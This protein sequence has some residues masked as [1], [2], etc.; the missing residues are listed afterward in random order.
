MPKRTPC[1]AL[2]RGVNVGAHGQVAMADLAEVLVTIGLSDV[3]TY[4]RSGNAVF[5]AAP[6]VRRGLAFRIEE[7]FEARFGFR[8]AV[9]V[10]G[11]DEFAR[12]ARDDPFARL[13]GVDGEGCYITFLL[14]EPA[15]RPEDEVRAAAGVT[16][17]RF[18]LGTGCVYVYCPDGYASTKL[19]TTFFERALSVA[20]T[21]RNRRTVM[22]LLAMAASA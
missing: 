12:I 2:F 13:G 17:D 6:D 5:V 14:D 8:S 4:I 1:I 21:T 18:A 9:L 22:R 16:G 11:A 20:A 15:D 10:I 19:S 7:A 3:R